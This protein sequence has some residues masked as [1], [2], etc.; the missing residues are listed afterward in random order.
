[1]R[2]VTGLWAISG[3]A[4]S[5]TRAERLTALRR[6]PRR[7]DRV[8]VGPDQADDELTEVLH[9]LRRALN[10]RDWI[11]SL[12][13]PHLGGDILEVGAGQG[14]LTDCLVERGRVTALEPSERS[15]G[16]LRRRH[17]HRENVRIVHGDV[18]AAAGLGPF[19]CVLLVNVLEHVAADAEAVQSLARTLRPA[20]K[21]AVF[22]PAFDGL[23]SDFDR[24]V[25][26]YRRYRAGG[27][28]G[29]ILDAG[30]ELVELRYVNS[31]GA[32]AW[33]VMAKQLRLTPTRPW[34][35]LP[36]DRHVVPRL[37]RLEER[38]KPP[39]GQSLFCVA[40][41]PAGPEAALTPA[42]PA[43]PARARAARARA[44]P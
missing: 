7:L 8:P 25:G 33:W 38:W 5:S 22:A 34:L 2:P 36:Y 31:F 30:L 23:Y 20:G 19:D 40:T 39:F 11:M 4:R 24:R 3:P 18:T 17:G 10:Y 15:F 41:R 37:R 29:L 42:R 13:D 26:H 27:L 28:G 43:P 14:C 44:W 21:L 16:E 1:M 6:R 32:L 9:G 12:L 35:A